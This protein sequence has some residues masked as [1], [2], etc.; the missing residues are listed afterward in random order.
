MGQQPKHHS[1]PQNECRT[2]TIRIMTPSRLARCLSNTP[3]LWFDFGTVLFSKIPKYDKPLRR[4]FRRSTKLYPIHNST[5]R[6]LSKDIEIS[7]TLRSQQQACQCFICIRR[8]QCAIAHSR[9]RC[10]AATRNNNT[11]PPLRPKEVSLIWLG[12]ALLKTG[13]KIGR[14]NIFLTSTCA[15]FLKHNSGRDQQTW[16]DR[17]EHLSSAPIQTPC[18]TLPRCLGRS[19]GSLAR[20]LHYQKQSCGFLEIQ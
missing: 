19:C 1:C 4:I 5:T 13:Q 12:A 18:S 17:R 11:S 3:L 8:L 7:Y 14:K 15:G 16:V 6:A 20:V 2:L 9:A 10:A